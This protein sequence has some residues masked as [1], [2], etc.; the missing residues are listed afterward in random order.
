MAIVLGLSQLRLPLQVLMSDGIYGK[1]MIQE[2]T[3]ARAIVDGVDPYLPTAVLAERYLG[4]LPKAVLSHPSP[5][6]PTVALLALP[7]AWLD[8]RTAAALWFGLELLCLVA[9]AYLLA[10]AAGARPSI[11]AT[12][13]ISSLLLI[14]YPFAI[15]L[16][17]GQLQVP[18]L[19][20][21]A[22]AWLALR[23]RQSA[24]A[25]ALVGLA[26]LL[27]TIPLPLLLLFLL[28]KDWR[29]LAAAIAVI[30]VGYCVAGCM[31]G[32]DTLWTY[33]TAVLP[34]VTT[35]Y[36]SCFGNY[37]VSSLAWRVFF[38]TE[39]TGVIIARPV[40]QSMAAARVASVGLPLLLWGVAYWAVRKQ[41]DLG[42]SWALLASVSILSTPIAWAY[43]LVLGAI[44]VAQ[45]IHWLARNR[46]PSRE[47][48][49][50]LV[51]AMLLLT[52]WTQ[53]GTMAALQVAVARRSMTLPFAVALL[54]VMPALAVGALAWL[55][56]RLG[57]VGMD[58]VSS[59]GGG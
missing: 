13:G 3:M 26:V 45:V 35:K 24:L 2:Y 56:V 40:I 14:W 47:T 36:R 7:L 55:V 32:L 27:K 9:S 43:Y 5:H 25:G 22:G 6:P 49:L 37:S 29:A 44:P 42:V 53:L 23:S 41:P 10:R 21:L 58:A 20:L 4:S 51:V 8:Y 34:A 39:D 38:G 11:P 31:L 19:A 16:A 18:M 33:F 59:P 17:W 54:P 46:L 48:N 1:D 50:A 12:L 30:S 57:P 15:D 28:M 52:P